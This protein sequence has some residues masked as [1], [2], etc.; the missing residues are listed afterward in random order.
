M[1]VFDK[2]SRICIHIVSF[3]G[4]Q[5]VEGKNY[6]CSAASKSYKRYQTMNKGII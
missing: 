2:H 1:K 6:S 4:L 5:M 3:N